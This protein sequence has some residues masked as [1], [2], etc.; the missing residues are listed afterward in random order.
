[1]RNILPFP[2]I[3]NI[4][5]KY[6]RVMAV[7]WKLAFVIMTSLVLV[8]VLAN[9]MLRYVKVLYRLIAWAAVGTAIIL[10]AN[11]ALERVGMHIPVNPVTILTVGILNIPGAL[12]LVV[13]NYYF[14]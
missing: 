11:V 6:E 4:L 1:M 3:I 14:V 8:F 5:K 13:L 12:L 7:E 2:R 9:L 10:L